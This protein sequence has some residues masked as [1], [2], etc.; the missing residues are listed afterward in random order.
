MRIRTLSGPL[1]PALALM[2]AGIASAA[3]PVAGDI[4]PNELGRTAQGQTVRI[5]DYRGRVVV[6]TFWASWCGPCL[7]ELT[8]LERLQRTA[9]VDRLRVVGVNWKESHDRF[10]AIQHRLQNFQLTLASDAKGRV[11]EQ[12][13]V[14]AIPRLFIIDQDGRVAYSHTGYDPESSIDAILD[15]VNELLAHPPSSMMQAS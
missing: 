2:V 5:S 15:E 11:G 4:P 8:L 10:L 13:G 7:R 9:G 1:L 12:Y 3:A 6:T 14:R